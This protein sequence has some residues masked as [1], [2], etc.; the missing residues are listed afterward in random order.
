[1]EYMTYNYFSEMHGIWLN[2]AFPLNAVAVP[3]RVVIL[4][5]VD[6]HVICIGTYY[7]KFDSL[8]VNHVNLE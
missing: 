6:A 7:V 1:M 8:V 4:G 5:C 2:E 3:G